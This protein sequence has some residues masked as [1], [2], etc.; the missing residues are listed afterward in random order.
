M[1]YVVSLMGQTL[2]TIV[3]IGYTRKIRIN[4]LELYNQV[5]LTPN[6]RLDP[7]HSVIV[8][9]ASLNLSLNCDFK[10]SS[11]NAHYFD[12][13]NATCDFLFCSTYIE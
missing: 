3:Y 9:T 7:T 2:L 13:D 11:S 10:V 12:F 1:S 4:I 8:Y 6:L 5:H